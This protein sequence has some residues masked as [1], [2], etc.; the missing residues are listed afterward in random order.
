MKTLNTTK[1]AVAAGLTMG[2]A[3]L[4]SAGPL[5]TFT[6]T[7]L[8]G[9]Y[10]YNPIGDTGAF[11]ATAVSNGALQSDGSVSLV[12]NPGAGTAVFNPGFTSRTIASFEIDLSFFGRVGNMASG[13]GTFKAVDTLGNI[14][15]GQLAGDWVMFGGAVFFNGAIRGAVLIP[16][17]VAVLPF[18]GETGSWNMGVPMALQPLDGS[19]VQIHLAEPVNSNMDHDFREVS[20]G[21]AG[22]LVPTPASMA[23]LGFGGLIAARRRR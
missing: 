11:K 20:T 14:L 10:A 22:Q 2:L 4:A 19:I 1:L 15:T 13:N 23:L 21:V 7:N 9:Q 6:Y 8:S 3:S 12:P 18:T 17:P 5:V 16:N